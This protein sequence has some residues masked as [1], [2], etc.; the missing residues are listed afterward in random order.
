MAGANAY[1]GKFVGNDFVLPKPKPKKIINPITVPYRQSVAAPVLSPALAESVA[2]EKIHPGEAI[3]N[4]I[5]SRLF[6]LIIIL[7]VCAAIVGVGSVVAARSHVITTIKVTATKI[8]RK[9]VAKIDRTSSYALPAN[10]EV[11]ESDILSTEMNAIENQLIN[12]NV[13]GL[14]VNPTPANVTQWLATGPGPKIGTTTLTVK[15]SALTAYLNTVIQTY[16]H[17][18][19]NQVTV[20]HSDN[21]TATIIK[22]VNG[23]IYAIPSGLI[24]SFSNQIL[25]SNGAA[26]TLTSS[27]KPFSITSKPPFDKLLEVDVTTK[28]MYAYQSGQLV[29]T[30]LVSAGAATTPTPIGQFKIYAKYPFQNIS[31]YNANGTSYYLPDVQWIDDFY[32][33]DAIV[34]N[35]WSPLTYFGYTNSSHGS[36]GVVTSEAEWIYNWAPIGTT[37][38][39]HQ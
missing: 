30:F 20:T 13:G 33:S 2:T 6:R 27:S 22:G 17:A 3:F 21:T 12:L 39:V 23:I 18:P 8:E 5:S 37:V 7:L 31:G 11:V 29:N 10:S 25:A 28:R 14:I 1:V 9:L 4:F 15:A 34:G 32:Q 36:V 35:N 16:D 19:V 26:A 24:H 38:I